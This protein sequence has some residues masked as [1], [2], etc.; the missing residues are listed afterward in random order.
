MCLL[1]SHARPVIRRRTHIM[2]TQTKAKPKKPTKPAT[3]KP[4]T[5]KPGSKKPPFGK[6][7][8][9]PG[10]MPSKPGC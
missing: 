9:K 7:P 3:T 1:F 8:F 5:T 6:P 2:A 4:A 10:G